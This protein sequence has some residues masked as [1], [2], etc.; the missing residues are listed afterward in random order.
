VTRRLRWFVAGVGVGVLASRR[1]AHTTTATMVGDAASSV[2]ARMRRVV[3]EVLDDVRGEMERR[4]ARLRE[5]LATPD[6]RATGA[7]ARRR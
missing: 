4:E 7:T 6:A 2:R 1:M 5:V 3:D